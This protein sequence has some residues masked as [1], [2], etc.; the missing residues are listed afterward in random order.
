MTV[1]QFEILFTKQNKILLFFAR[2]IVWDAQV[3]EDMVAEA[4]A[5]GF[6]KISSINNSDKMIN[7]I[8]V[9]M[10]NKCKDYLKHVNRTQAHHDKIIYSA[11]DVGELLETKMIHA[12]TIG[13]ILSQVDQLAPQQREIFYLHY[14]EELPV[15][16]I[17]AKI[18]LSTDTIRVQKARALKHLR[19]SLVTNKN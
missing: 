6:G 9:V 10:K 19:A 4:W 2:K 12:E 1:K 18:G 7:L 3:A 13:N 11:N 17:A 14:I 15:K 16:Q 5:I 8:Y